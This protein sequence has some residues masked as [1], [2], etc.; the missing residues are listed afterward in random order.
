MKRTGRFRDQSRVVVFLV[1]TVGQFLDRLRRE[2]A[3]DVAGGLILVEQ[4]PREDL[5]EEAVELASSVASA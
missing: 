5:F 4:N 1:H 3:I 2:R